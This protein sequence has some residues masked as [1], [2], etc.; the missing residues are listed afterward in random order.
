MANLLEPTIELIAC[1]FL[2]DNLIDPTFNDLYPYLGPLIDWALPPP[3]SMENYPLDALIS[4]LNLHYNSGEAVEAYF[5]KFIKPIVGTAPAI[6]LAFKLLG[7]DATISEWYEQSVP[8]APFLF[9]ITF[10]TYPANLDINALLDLIFA[11]KNERSWPT[12]I[13][14]AEC[15]DNLVWDIGY[16]DTEPMDASEGYL[17]VDNYTLCLYEYFAPETTTITYTPFEMFK[18]I[19]SQAYKIGEYYM[20]DYND[21]DEA[22]NDFWDTVDEGRETITEIY[23][24]YYLPNSTCLLYADT[25]TRPSSDYTWAFTP[26][27]T[28]YGFGTFLATEDGSPLEYDLAE[29]D[30]QT[31]YCQALL[32]NIE[33]YWTATYES[34]LVWSDGISVLDDGTGSIA[35][36]IDTG[37]QQTW[38]GTCI[39]DDFYLQVTPITQLFFVN[40]SQLTPDPFD[41][42]CVST[43]LT[44][45][46]DFFDASALTG[47]AEQ[48]QIVSWPWFVGVAFNNVTLPFAYESHL[49]LDITGIPSGALIDE[50]GDWIVDE[51]GDPIVYSTG[52]IMNF[53]D[54]AESDLIGAIL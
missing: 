26:I 1:D 9:V 53:S 45:Q 43:Q 6:S 28:D 19:Y 54:P 37:P 21:L 17:T 13:R 42:L 31:N 51:S 7:L 30:R 52:S 2:P 29:I 46:M 48:G 24:T 40:H 11:L 36:Y 10:N 32:T 25:P 22:W 33:L 23:Y 18:G 44:I 50:E 27:C 34:Q 14:M 3:P 15:L 16:L 39:L 8:T 4:Q 12:T 38:D 35:E 41:E 49:T 5:N 20:W 47:S